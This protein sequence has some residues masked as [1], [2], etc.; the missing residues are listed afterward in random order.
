MALELT[1]YGV[2]VRIIDSMTERAKTSRAVAIW[3]RTL[4]LLDRAGG[5]AA[6]IERGNKGEPCQHRGRQQT[7]GPHLP[8]IPSTRPIRSSSCCR[9][10]RPKGC[11]WSGS[12]RAASVPSWA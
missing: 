4:E 9:R 6:F 10:R 8:S 2:P 5:S 3:S 7:A 12:R 11:S 1:R